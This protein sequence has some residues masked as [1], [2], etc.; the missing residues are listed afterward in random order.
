MY[1]NSNHIC[2]VGQG[3]KC[4]EA[5]KLLTRYKA[6]SIVSRGQS[7]YVNTAIRLI[8]NFVCL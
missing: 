7:R 2:N 5:V 6:K 4:A 3:S 8:V 1:I